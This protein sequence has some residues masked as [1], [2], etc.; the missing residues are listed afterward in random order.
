[1]YPQTALLATFRDSGVI[2]IWCKRFVADGGC[3]Q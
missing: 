1:V 2:Q 3:R